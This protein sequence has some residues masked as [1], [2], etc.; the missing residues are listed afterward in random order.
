MRRET[1]GELFPSVAKIIIAIREQ[2]TSFVEKQ[3][4]EYIATY[5]PDLAASF[6]FECLNK[7]CTCGVF[8]LY[9]VIST[10]I[11]H[12]ENYEEGI[13]RCEGKESRK[14]LSVSCPCELRYKITIEYK[15]SADKTTPKG[16]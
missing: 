11:A 9:N 16:V 15:K 8:D 13:A 1:I 2:Y 14:Y 3:N 6:E 5:T 10:I 7:D 4:V 12:G